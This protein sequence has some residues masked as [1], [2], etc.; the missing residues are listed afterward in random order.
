MK[1]SALKSYTAENKE[2]AEKDPR[3]LSPR[4]YANAAQ[5]GAASLDGAFLSPVPSQR[6]PE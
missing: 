4:L 5:Q 3:D 6:I 1:A 2:G